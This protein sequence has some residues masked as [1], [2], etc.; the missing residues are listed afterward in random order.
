LLKGAVTCCILAFYSDEPISTDVDE[1]KDEIVLQ[2]C[3]QI[4]HTASS[5]LYRVPAK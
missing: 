1:H 5:Y 3:N 2:T 4:K